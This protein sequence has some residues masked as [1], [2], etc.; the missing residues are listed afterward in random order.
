M[1]VC[2]LLSICAF[3]QGHSV[4]ASIQ[5]RAGRK[6]DKNLFPFLRLF[7]PMKVML[8]VKPEKSL[9]ESGCAYFLFFFFFSLSQIALNATELN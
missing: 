6:E 5:V 2:Q 1:T 3:H 7:S 8:Q 4:E 9:S